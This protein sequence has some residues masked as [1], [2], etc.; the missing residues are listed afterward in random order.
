MTEALAERSAGAVIEGR[1]ADIRDRERVMRLMGEFKPEHR[2][3]CR[4]P[5]ACA[6]PRARLERRRQDEYLR[7]GQRCHAAWR[8]RRSQVMISTH[9]AI[10][11]AR[12]PLTKRF[13]GRDCQALDQT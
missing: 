13:A 12:C 3:P 10:E 4:R 1:I 8:G 9:K 2:V 6:D 7:I 5:Q 11:P